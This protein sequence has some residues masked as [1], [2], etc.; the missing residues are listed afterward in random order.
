MAFSQRFKPYFLV[1]AFLSK[2]S[3]AV[4]FVVSLSACQTVVI[5]RTDMQEV[6]PLQWPQELLHNA[7]EGALPY[8]LPWWEFVNDPNLRQVIADA[9]EYNRD[10]QMAVLRI[11]EAE[12]ILQLRRSD[13]WPTIGVDGQ[14]SRSRVP[15][16]MSLG[17]T[18]GVGSE[19][20][21]SVGVSSW[22][23]DLWGRVRALKDAALEEFLAGSYARHSVQAS[24]IAEVARV[25]LSLQTLDEQIHIAQQSIV[26]RQESYRIFKRRYE[27][28]ASSLLELTQVETLL[29]QARVLSSQLQQERGDL[30]HALTV[31][32]GR[33]VSFS[34][35]GA[36]SRVSRRDGEVSFTP[37]SV[38]VPSEVLL[39][40]PDVVAAEHSIR[41]AQANVVA[42]R[43]AYFPRI[44]LTTAAGTASAQLSGLFDGGSGTW[45]FSPDISLAIFDGGARAANLEAAQIRAQMAVVDYEKVVQQAFREVS[46]ALNHRLHLQEQVKLGQR[47][48]QIQQERA[49]LAQL[50]YNS[51][52]VSY[53][54]VLDAEREL[55]SAQQQLA[56]DQGSLR[57][58]EVELYSALG[59]GTEIPSEQSFKT[60]K[61]AVGSSEL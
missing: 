57:L 4:L 26:S 23:L 41:A 45:L 1:P 27:V 61:V 24:L 20:G 30:A 50:R 32:V 19:Y 53:L 3:L 48:V 6:I 14:A 36:I 29:M 31:L 15:A 8:Q 7:P 25:Y 16:D 44:A 5:D 11:A 60:T 43:A 54:E 22:E 49:R 21:L 34:D 2:R 42:A 52:A 55:L 56:Q 13:Q 47:V 46:D 37:I 51:G 35:L 28:G 33:S 12:A 38:G 17:Q 40:R 9:L 18:A 10:L 59:G 39:Q 58:S